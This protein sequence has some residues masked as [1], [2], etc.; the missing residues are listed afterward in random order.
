MNQ[1]SLKV[2]SENGMVLTACAPEAVSAVYH[3]TY[4]PGDRIALGIS[5][6]N[7]HYVIQLEDS[8]PPAI[9]YVRSSHIVFRVPAPDPAGT[10]PRAYSPKS[11]SGSCHIIRVRLAS[12]EEIAARRNLAFN[13]YDAQAAAAEQAAGKG[14]GF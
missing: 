5:E 8:M 7:R 10:I 14:I 3:G 9:V 12:L 2:Y 4:Q 13:P 11:F 6:L 1:I